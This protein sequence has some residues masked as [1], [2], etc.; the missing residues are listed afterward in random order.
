MRRHAAVAVAAFLTVTLLPAPASA[1]PGELDLSFGFDGIAS[2]FG[3][4]GGSCTFPNDVT[5]LA[6]GRI[7]L[8]GVA[9]T[10]SEDR[11]GI[12]AVGSVFTAEGAF[13]AYGFGPGIHAFLDASRAIAPLPDG[14]AMVAGWLQR[15]LD[16]LDPCGE[17]SRSAFLVTRSLP[18]GSPDPTFGRNGSTRVLLGGGGYADGVAVQVDGGVVATG[19]VASV[20]GRPKVAAIRLLPDGALDPAFGQGGRVLRGGG[21]MHDV[22]VDAEGRIVLAGDAR[23]GGFLV[24][25]LLPDG[26]VDPEFGED[27]RV[28]VNPGGTASGANDV[29]VQP[30]GGVI[31]AGWVEI[32]DDELGSVRRFALT[33]LLDDGGL[34]HAFGRGG[35]VRSG[36]GRGSAGVDEIVLQPDGRIVAGGGNGVTRYTADGRR[37]PTFGGDGRAW[38]PWEIEGLALQG[39]GLLVGVNSWDYGMSAARILR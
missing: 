26:S 31:V 1:A 10:E 6:D 37:D 8:I 15:C 21:Q 4:C 19:P 22:E 24:V 38:L 29:L 32:L 27:G 14:G 5:V 11:F 34:D 3:G 28:V 12:G 30:D 23:G 17:V 9:N 18:D 39:D 35:L 13:D 33:R 20:L 7:V 25:R 16:D 2:D 36:F